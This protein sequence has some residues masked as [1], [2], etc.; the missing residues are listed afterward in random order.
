MGHKI[1]V[2]A[3]QMDAFPAT[4]SERL[5]RAENLVSEAASSGAELIV[6]PELFNTGYQYDDANYKLAE[7]IDGQT[8]GW[9]NET[10]KRN[11]IYLAGS[12][13]LRD[14]CE[15]YNTAFLVAPDGNYWRYDKQF[16]WFHERAYF[17]AGAA[18]QV[19]QTELGDIG[20]LICWD[21]AH[22]HLWQTYAGNVDALI[23]MSSP[24]K[25][26]DPDLIFPDGKRLPQRD[27]GPLYRYLHT[28]EEYFPSGDMDVF[29][30]WIGVPVIAS[31]G[32]GTVRL[33][34][35][36][37]YL[38]MPFYS[39]FRP[40]L[41][42]RFYQFKDMYL[43]AGFDKQT[44]VIDADGNVL[45]RVT[46]AGDGITL[47]QIDISDERPKPN[48]PPPKMRTQLPVYFFSDVFSNW[49]YASYYDKHKSLESS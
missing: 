24:P 7:P 15:I 28:D 23:I 36:R 31:S 13:L 32:A 43:E 29:A 49:V 19:A 35:P 45:S 4:V 47:A 12:F 1:R 8:M 20:M 14:G 40:D 27:L 22:P 41:W 26:S 5:D 46:A 37:P 48:I 18:P 16:P 38:A 25:M 33:K 11:R 30:D 39:A 9:M 21:V 17:R 2:S 34:M 42:G 44:K 10:A 6:L 3:I